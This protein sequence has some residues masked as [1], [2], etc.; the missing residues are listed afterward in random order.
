[1]IRHL[2]FFIDHRMKAAKLKL[3]LVETAV[4]GVSWG[5]GIVGDICTV[6]LFCL[7]SNMITERSSF[8]RLCLMV[9]WTAGS[10]QQVLSARL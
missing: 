10:D 1:M 7:C 8:V 4:T 2:N 6:A 5:W 3:R 9:T